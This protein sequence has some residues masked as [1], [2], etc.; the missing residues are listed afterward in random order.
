MEH[1]VLTLG[2]TDASV[3]RGI[4]ALT[5]ARETL[6]EGTV[7]RPRAVL[8]FADLR[9]HSRQSGKERLRAIASLA[10]VETKRHAAIRH[11]VFAV[12]LAP[13]HAAAFDRIASSLGARVSSTSPPAAPTAAASEGVASPK[14]IAPSTERMRS[15]RGRNEVRSIHDSRAM[16]TSRNAPFSGRGATEGWTIA[17]IIT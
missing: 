11:V 15:A 2:D 4:L 14:R 9:E 10:A 12:L 16:P 1:P 3:A 17:R 7:E 8:A 5:N 13:R 6:D